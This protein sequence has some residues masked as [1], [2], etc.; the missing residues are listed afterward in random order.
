MNPTPSDTRRGFGSDN[1]AGAHPEVLAAISAA[2]DGHV[3]AYGDDPWT[4]RAIEIVQ[5]HVGETAG[6]APDVALVWNGTGANVVALSALCRPWESVICPATAHINMDECGAPEHIANVKLVPVASPDGKLTPELVRPHLTGFGFE[7]HAQPKVISVSNVSEFGTVYRPEELRALADL[8]HE[9]GMYLHVDGARISNACAALGVPMSALTSE[10]GVDALSLG[11]TKNGAVALEAVVLLG[12]AR[13][14]AL[15]YVRKQSAQLA[16]KMRFVAA[17]VIAMFGGD[18][19]LQLA[20]HANAMAARLA[21]GAADAG[22]VLAQPAEANEVFPLLTPEQVAAT[23]ERFRYYVWDETPTADGRICVR[24]VA[25]WDTAEEDV[26][27]LLDAL[28]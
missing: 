6:A 8:A 21:T 7:H 5:E 15:P 14:D 1:H 10:V 25:S 22:I 20:G 4:A 27:A 19:W 28:A 17:Q 26:D 13:T 16:S 11:G 23:Q 12:D 2:S 18:L 24:W 3:P 9:H